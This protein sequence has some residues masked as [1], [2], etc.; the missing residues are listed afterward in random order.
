MTQ[1]QTRPVN[2]IFCI[3]KNYEAHAREMGGEVDRAQPFH[4]Q[5]R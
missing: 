3:G 4:F 1:G 2:G 5:K